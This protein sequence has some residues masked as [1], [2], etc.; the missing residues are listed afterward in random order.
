M[1]CELNDNTLK[2]YIELH[3]Q[4]RAM[5][6][7]PAPEV[8]NRLRRKARQVLDGAVLPRKGD[9][10]YEATSLDRLLAPDYGLNL[11]RR[12][13]D[14]DAAASFRCDVPNMSTCMFYM[15]NDMFH[16][17][18]TARLPQGVVVT[19][20]AQ[21]AQ[22][23]P[24]LLERYYGRMATPTNPL[25]A[26]NTLLAQ[27]GIFIYVPDGVVLEKPIQIVN[28]I[29]H[30]RPMMVVRRLL[31]VMGEGAGARVLACD[32]TQ[33]AAVECL[34]LQVVEMALER[35]ATLDYYDLEE[36]S[37][38]T[39]RLSVMAARQ[40][41][42]SNLLIDGITLTN[43]VTRNEYCIDVNGE[44]AETQL[45][46]M[47]VASGTQHVDTHSLINHNAPRCKSNEMFKYVLN[48][49]AVGAFAGKILVKPSCP[50]VEAYQG[51]RNLCASPTAKMHS[52]PQ[53]EIYTD[54]VKCSHGT[55]IGQ[56]DEEALFYMRTRGIGL[57]EAR[58]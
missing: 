15:F 42:E 44:R 38:A 19:S 12:D 43:G 47:T 46:G 33:S 25:V 39:R 48:D 14:I 37:P 54:D 28:L 20:L 16:A 2:Q 18:P 24:D 40:E 36:T 10:D 8:I 23:C 6:E 13:F 30:A 51:N 32:H 5:V 31:I 7:K 58:M 26:L 57:K 55:T 52:K 11:T 9:E 50:R 49:Q 53:L 41:A 1:N 35:G 21:A 17:A 27:D 56:L 22:A 4:H 3:D 29:N 45:L 34:N